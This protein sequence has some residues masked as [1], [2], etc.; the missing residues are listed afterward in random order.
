M[1]RKLRTPSHRRRHLA[2]YLLAT[3][4]AVGFLIRLCVQLSSRHNRESDWESFLPL[5]NNEPDYCTEADLNSNKWI[6]SLYRN[7]FESLYSNCSKVIRIGSSDDGGKLVCTDSLRKDNCVI[8]SLGSNLEF[9]FEQDAKNKLGCDIFT[10]DC[11]VGVIANGTIPRDI[12]FYPWCVGGRDEMK[13]I[14]SNFGYTGELGQYF[15][16]ET[17]MKKL[18]HQRVDLLKMDIER[19]EV[20]VINSLHGQV[21]PQQILFETHLH[22]AYGVWGRPMLRKEWSTMWQTLGSLGYR[23]FSYEP[24]PLCLCCCEWSVQLKSRLSQW[25]LKVSF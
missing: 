8:Y 10:F 17:I 21:I 9:S 23:T 1:R 15:S 7:R 25:A 3:T 13:V 5:R 2:I 20:H 16:M 22:N 4:T 14:S 11:T 19:H 6:T 24:N 18:S 12:H